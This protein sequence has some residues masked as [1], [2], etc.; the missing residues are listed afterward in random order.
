[1]V[2]YKVRV[3]RDLK[4]LNRYD[5]TLITEVH[6]DGPNTEVLTVEVQPRWFRYVWF[7]RAMDDEPCVLSYQE[8]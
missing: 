5:G 6:Q 8:A 7:E 3:H 1:M 4:W 2:T